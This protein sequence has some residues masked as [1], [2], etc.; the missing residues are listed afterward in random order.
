MTSREKLMSSRSKLMS[1]SERLAAS[2][3][4][5]TIPCDQDE[6]CVPQHEYDT[7]DI[8]G[9]DTTAEEPPAD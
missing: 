2:V 7:Y 8:P 6:Q 9:R 1:S 4:K 5:L 3:E